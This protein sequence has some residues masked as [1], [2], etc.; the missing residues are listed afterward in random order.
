MLINS[1]NSNYK[2]STL[3]PFVKPR[4]VLRGY[5]DVAIVKICKTFMQS[6]A[7]DWQTCS[8]ANFLQWLHLNTIAKKLSVKLA[9][10]GRE[11]IWSVKV[12]V[13]QL[14]VAGNFPKAATAVLM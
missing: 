12:G 14:E 7:T 1:S 8:F 3:T 11:N 5:L 13:H 6:C 4:K 2:T 9:K 10:N